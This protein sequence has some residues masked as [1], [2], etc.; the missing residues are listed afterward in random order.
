ML[1]TLSRRPRLIAVLHLCSD[2]ADVV[3]H[4]VRQALMARDH[5]ADGCAVIPAGIRSG[6][7]P[8]VTEAARRIRAAWPECFLVANYM[9]TPADAMRAVPMEVDALWTDK[10]VGPV[11]GKLKVSPT[12]GIAKVAA[13]MAEVRLAERSDWKGMWFAGF[14]HKGDRNDVLDD[15]IAPR[16]EEL[17]QG[18]HA[19]GAVTTGAG[20]GLPA[21]PHDVERIRKALGPGLKL[22]IASGVTGKNVAS[23]CPYVDFFF[24]GTGIEQKDPSLVKQYT[25]IYNTS[26]EVAS[27]IAVR[28]GELDPARVRAIAEAIAAACNT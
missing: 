3:G 1:P 5:G 19:E 4:A 11:G 23:Y 18:L 8:L 25:K 16:V 26:E 7:T 21:D 17:T 9:T 14:F 10:G 20:T 13:E 6:A 15:D 24:V 27:E 28:Q 22:A 2:V 12:S